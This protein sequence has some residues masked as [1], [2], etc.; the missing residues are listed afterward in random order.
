MNVATDWIVFLADDDEINNFLSRAVL[1]EFLPEDRVFDFTS[2]GQMLKTAC[3]I[4][5]Q[6]AG[7]S[8]IFFIDINMPEYNGW[9][10]INQLKA[11]PCFDF[12]GKDN[13]YILSSSINPADQEKAKKE[14]A[15]SGFLEKPLGIKTVAEVFDNMNVTGRPIIE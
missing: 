8:F 7:C 1:E 4:S 9:E 15:I 3:S 11:L 6:K 10:L 5:A 2:P 13:I 14:M 12:P